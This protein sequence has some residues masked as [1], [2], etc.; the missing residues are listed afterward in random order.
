MSEDTS[1]LTVRMDPDAMRAVLTIEPGYGIVETSARDLLG[2]FVS[3]GVRGSEEIVAAIDAG[4]A[5]YRAQ[6]DKACSIEVR[7]REPVAGADGRIEWTVGEPQ[8]GPADE[9]QRVDHYSRSQIVCVRAGE[10]LAIIRPAERGT[11]GRDLLGRDAAARDG[12]EALV[13]HDDSVRRQGPRLVAARDGALVREGDSVRVT[14]DLVIDGAIDFSTG[15]LDFRG[16]IEARGGIRDNFRVRVSR[17]LSVHGTIEGAFIEVRGDLTARAGIAGRDKARIRVGGSARVRYLANT[18]ADIARDL[19]VQKEVVASELIVGGAL[20]IEPGAL[21]GG[22]THALGAVS[23][24]AIGSVGHVP[25]ILHLG[26]APRIARAMAALRDELRRL[27]RA[28]ASVDQEVE[29]L[30]AQQRSLGEFGRQRLELLR[31][32]QTEFQARQDKLNTMLG[33][34]E[35]TTAGLRT[36]ELR[37][38]EMIHT[39]VT[40]VALGKRAAFHADLRG[41]LRIT[42]DD[43]AAFQVTDERDGVT[44]PLMGFARIEPVSE[45]ARAA[46]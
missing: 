46:A 44:R 9:S 13:E 22:V 38:H 27:T 31:A 3:L 40:L 43:Q 39:G 24:G 2:R 30:N 29:V 19:F 4:L 37:V 23:V 17:D 26:S 1:K 15:S 11:P 8:R 5:R 33:E 20:R 16:S 18:D 21:V 12:R 25:T 35:R 36:I 14:N 10:E 34:L 45:A 28:R 42:L 41:P 6:P 32:Q 7:G